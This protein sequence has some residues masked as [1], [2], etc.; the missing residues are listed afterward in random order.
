MTGEAD[1]P[2]RLAVCVISRE[3]TPVMNDMI[4]Q[5]LRGL[6]AKRVRI[7]AVHLTAGD[8]ELV[9]LVDEVCEW[10][11]VAPDPAGWNPLANARSV[12]AQLLGGLR[13]LVAEVSDAAPSAIVYMEGDKLSF[14]DSLEAL[15]APILTGGADVTLATRS[16]AGWREFPA[17]QRAVESLV[18]RA[19][20]RT[21]GLR[22]DYLYGPRAF[23]LEAASLFSEYPADDWG[24]MMYPVVAAIARGMRCVPVEVP[25]APQPRYMEKYDRLMRPAPAHFLWRS[26]QNAGILRATSAVQKAAVDGA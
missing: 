18:N 20:S 13:E 11:H 3:G 4:R 24:V 26:L 6:A 19:I 1:D 2:S 25:G 16:P 7:G 8:D 9:A 10:S 23:S 12:S 14:P 17:V 21:T 5:T 15:A 22:T